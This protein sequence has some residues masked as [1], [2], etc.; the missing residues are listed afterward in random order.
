MGRMATPCKP[1][2][3]EVARAWEARTGAR[4]CPFNGTRD[5]GQ[6]AVASPGDPAEKRC[7]S[8]RGWRPE[9]GSGCARSHCHSRLGRPMD[10]GR[11]HDLHGG[12]ERPR[13]RQGGPAGDDHRYADQTEHRHRGGRGHLPLRRDQFAIIDSQS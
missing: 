4:V 11:Q 12:P 7:M 8:D 5:A 10:G 2:P 3:R 13:G 9:P 1:M 6:L